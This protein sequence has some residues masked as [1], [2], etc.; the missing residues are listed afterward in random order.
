[1]P[2]PKIA[3]PE[4]T[5]KLPSTGKNVKYRPFLVKEEKLLLLAMETGDQKQ[6]VDT[7]KNIIKSC[8]NITSKV[9]ELPTFDIEY[10]FLQIRSKSVGETSTVLITCPD[11]GETDVEVSINLQEVEV[12]HTEGHDTKIDLDGKV[13][14]IMKY[15][16][17]DTFVK[18]NLSTDND[19]K[20][21]V[22]QIFDLAADCI[23]QIYDENQVYEAKDVKRSE[24]IEFLEQLNTDQFQKIQKFFETMPKLKQDLEVTNPNTGVTSTV[25]LEG[26][27]SFFG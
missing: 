11:D 19:E 13:G 10:V 17:L 7:V 20:T 12:Q 8:T 25:T 9:D 6:I 1:M 27:G 14:M 16:S 24:R 15:P 4:Y 22:E 23:E 3:V 21:Q 2:L 5:L 26:L 18:M